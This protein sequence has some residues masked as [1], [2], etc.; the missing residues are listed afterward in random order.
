MAAVIEPRRESLSGSAPFTMVTLVHISL[1]DEM[2]VAAGSKKAVADAGIT[3]SGLVFEAELDAAVSLDS[4]ASLFSLEGASLVLSLASFD[5]LPSLGS[6]GSFEL[7]ESRSSLEGF[8]SF[9]V[10]LEAAGG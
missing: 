4:F 8:S 10:L 7:D 1:E 6:L 2:T 3:A 9:A 5:S